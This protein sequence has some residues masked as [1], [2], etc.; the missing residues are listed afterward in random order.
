MIMKKNINLIGGGFQHAFSATWWKKPKYLI[1]DYNS[2]KNGITVYVDGGIEM[3]LKDDEDDKIKYGWLQESKLMAPH[4]NQRIKN[5]P[6]KYLNTLKGI[7][8]C[9]EDLLKIDKRF[10]WV[11]ACGV[12]I[13]KYGGKP[14]TNLISMITSKKVMTPQQ[15][16]RVNFA[17]K[18]KNKLHLF[19]NGY[20]HIQNKEKGLDN[21]MFSIAIENATYDTYFTE[22]IID[23]FAT[24]TIPIY[25][26]TKKVTNFFNKNGIIFFR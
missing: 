16:F 8:T 25:K 22:K 19:G 12:W 26:G 21:Y 13:E 3:S 2:K 14:K 9:D 17:N 5:D 10:L 20:N 6:L 24:K 18:N 1:W 11:P 7:F 4:I 23:C 15:Q